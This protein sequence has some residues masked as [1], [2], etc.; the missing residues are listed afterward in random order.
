MRRFTSRFLSVLLCLL[1]AGGTLRLAVGQS[2]DTGA[3]SGLIDVR[4]GV[5]V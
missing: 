5:R 3:I 2:S 4:C 1:L